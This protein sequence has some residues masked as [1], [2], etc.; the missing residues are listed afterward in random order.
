MFW[1]GTISL[2]AECYLHD[3]RLAVSD[4]SKQASDHNQRLITT[5]II[6]Q[7]YKN[8][9]NFGFLRDRLP[10]RGKAQMACDLMLPHED[11]IQNKF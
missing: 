2:M 7:I 5:I 6:I 10:R 9:R 8:G 1:F 4:R 3:Y 11:V